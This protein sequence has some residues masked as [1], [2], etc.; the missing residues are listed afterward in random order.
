MEAVSVVR[1]SLSV[2]IF[3]ILVY[4]VQ[5]D[6]ICFS[7]SVTFS[8]LKIHFILFQVY[9]SL[10]C[11]SI[12]AAVAAAAYLHPLWKIVG[13]L[14]TFVCLGCS[15]WHL[16]VPSKEEVHPRE[17]SSKLPFFYLLFLIGIVKLQ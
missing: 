4:F 10:C 7:N 12:A 11:A 2:E 15:I 6:L 1:L 8:Y 17:L 16:C 5:S 14:I 9:L 3:R 13:H